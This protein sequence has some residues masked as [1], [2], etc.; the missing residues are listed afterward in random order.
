[1]L[2]LGWIF[3]LKIYFSTDVVFAGVGW[4]GEVLA[5]HFEGGS[6]LVL[7]GIESDGEIDCSGHV[8]GK[9]IDEIG[10]QILG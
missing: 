9:A 4:K 3:K 5:L 6:F 10:N 8:R 7:G 1:M 2:V